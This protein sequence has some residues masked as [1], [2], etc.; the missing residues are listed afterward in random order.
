MYF[1]I[2]PLNKILKKSTIKHE[3]DEDS[4]WY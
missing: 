3:A 4:D 1:L 2:G